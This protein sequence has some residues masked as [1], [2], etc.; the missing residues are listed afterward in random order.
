MSLNIILFISVSVVRRDEY[1]LDFIC[2]MDVIGVA[3]I[4]TQDVVNSDSDHFSWL[5]QTVVTSDAKFDQQLVVRD[6][7]G[8]KLEL[9]RIITIKAV[10]DFLE[11]DRQNNPLDIETNAHWPP[12][13]YRPYTRQQSAIETWM[14]IS[15]HTESET[16][17]GFTQPIQGCLSA[18]VGFLSSQKKKKSKKHRI[19]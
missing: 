16:C 6:E 14:I 3:N 5:W 18:I 1:F 4:N 8:I 15:C 19:K 7:L 11:K 12:Y 13:I 2:V 10:I 9:V 17:K